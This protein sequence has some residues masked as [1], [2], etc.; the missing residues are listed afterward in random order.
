MYLLSKKGTP[1]PGGSHKEVCDSGSCGAEMDA[2]VAVKK[3]DN[4]TARDKPCNL[5]Q[6]IVILEPFSTGWH[7]VPPVYTNHHGFPE[8]FR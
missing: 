7:S 3:Q 6:F 4:M 2:W 8:N 1:P 5:P